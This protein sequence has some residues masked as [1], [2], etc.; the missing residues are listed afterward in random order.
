MQRAP[1]GL[2]RKVVLASTAALVALVVIGGILYAQRGLGLARRDAA[3]ALRATATSKSLQISEW[4]R[5]RL[6]DAA[7]R[8]QDPLFV[9]S[10]RA[11]ING[12]RSPAFVERLRGSITPKRAPWRYLTISI[13][14]RDGAPVLTSLGRSSEMTIEPDLANACLTQ[15]EPVFGVLQGAG[16]TQPY[17]DMCTT[18]VDHSSGHSE[19]L[20]G[21]LSR[22][23][24]SQL[25]LPT[26]R[27]WPFRSTTAA[28]F[29][30]RNTNGRYALLLS[31]DARDQLGE[32]TGRIPPEWLTGPDGHRE[33]IDGTGLPILAEVQSIANLPWLL[34]VTMGRSE[35]E[36]DAYAE[37]LLAGLIALLLLATAGLAAVLVNE[38]RSRGHALEI[39]RF[40]R[41]LRIRS[42]VNETIVRVHHRPAM[43]DRFCEIAVSLGGFEFAAIYEVL[44]EGSSARL[45]SAAGKNPGRIKA[46]VTYSLR[47]GP[48]EQWLQVV[49]GRGEVALHP[50]LTADERD[51]WVTGLIAAGHRAVIIIPIKENG[52]VS[53]LF[54]LYSNAAGV[55]DHRD[56]QLFVELGNDISHA[57]ENVE[58]DKRRRDVESQLHT[59]S[60]A[61]PFAMFLVSSSDHGIKSANQA[62]L[63]QY[64]YSEAELIGRDA[65]E[66]LT[67][68]YERA[69]AAPGAEA[70][71]LPSAATHVTKSGKKIQV[72]VISRRVQIDGGHDHI[73]VAIDVTERQQLEE[74][75]QQRQRLEAVGRLAG[76]V[77]HDFNNL[78]TVIGGFA[79]FVL[80]ELPS[81]S[82]ARG[83]A[84]QIQTAATRAAEL[85]GRLLAF[86]RRQTLRIEPAALNN[87]VRETAAMLDR[88]I[89][90]DIVVELQLRAERDT[91]NLDLGQMQQVIMNLAVNARDAM[92]KGGRLTITTIDQDGCIELRVADTGEGMPAEV[93]AHI[94]EPFFT[95]KPQGEGTGLGL[96][97][98]HGIVTQS[99]G[100]IAVD[101]AKGR[102]T[103]FTITLPL[104]N[105]APAPPAVPK[106]R[107]VPNGSAT[108][109]LVEDDEG[110]RAL[111]RLVLGRGGFTVI[112]HS[113]GA[114]AYECVTNGSITAVDL[115]LTDVVMPG[116]SGPELAE[117][118]RN[119]YPRM[120]VLFISGYAADSAARNGFDLSRLDLL[121]KPFAPTEL[122]SRIRAALQKA[123]DA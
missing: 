109:L 20:A 50:D 122:L 67:D 81:D 63:R 16:S 80:E 29:L 26:V 61:A 68:H 78:L 22:I 120:G 7:G 118:L 115:L 111:T 91:V 77:A 28:T 44:D 36:S 105:E 37:I 121:H 54:A 112:E 31:S 21:Y 123:A 34:V 41:L 72:E 43:L 75:F 39:L 35:V 83:P 27:F 12:E 96:A 55:F 102:G 5:E 93:V 33:G 4:Y 89:G 25:L 48:F 119:Y 85:T 95:T 13:L 87:V 45:V 98:V 19:I 71:Y 84:E 38:R 117:S 11:W 1:L 23:D 24:A 108:I 49:F 2:T 94:F 9:A 116:I 6:D 114:A 103:T 99:G 106:A 30:I 59:I 74:K 14:N 57:L 107:P 76:G 86:S 70:N 53:G 65:R 92:R 3:G 66:I 113:S 100:T 15:P 64:G 40:D 90:E 58:A 52:V 10:L 97:S 60:D 110:V 104:S 56:K 88:L 18:V 47:D 101:T 42:G 73:V 79:E 51:P 32:G 82:A 69:S 62:A 46:G 17:I 8:A